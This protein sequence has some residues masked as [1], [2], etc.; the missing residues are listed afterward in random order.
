MEAVA[1]KRSFALSQEG[2]KH[3]FNSLRHTKEKPINLSGS[4]RKI[5]SEEVEQQTKNLLSN[6]EFCDAAK[7]LKSSALFEEYVWKQMNVSDAVYLQIPTIL[8]EGNIHG[9][10]FIWKAA[11]KLLKDRLETAYDATVL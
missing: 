2:V 5:F 3:M 10:E 1:I 9:L 4:A 11:K 7:D 8:G 6:Y